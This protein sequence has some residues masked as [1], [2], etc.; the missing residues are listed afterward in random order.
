MKK[1][2]LSVL[3]FSLLSNIA[4]VMGS[5]RYLPERVAMHFNGAG[6]PDR[7]SDKLTASVLIGLLSML[8]LLIA[9]VFLLVGNKRENKRKANKSFTLCMSLLS[10]GLTSIVM[11]SAMNEHATSGQFLFVVI[12]AFLIITGNDIPTFRNTAG[13]PYK[14][15]RV[16]GFTYCLLG[17]IFIVSAF[18][19]LVVAIF[20]CFFSFS[21]SLVVIALYTPKTR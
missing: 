13:N 15:R 11:I 21:G 20:L 19:P 6:N 18:L 9:C 2:Q 16:Q 3:I 1:S 14:Q 10:I 4:I 7:Y 5:Y 8:P 12:G 17:L